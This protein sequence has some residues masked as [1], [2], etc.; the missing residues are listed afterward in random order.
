[1]IPGL[2]VEPRECIPERTVG[3]LAAVL[4]RVGMSRRMSSASQI[5]VLS[6]SCRELER[7]ASIQPS[8]SDPATFAKLYI[9]SQIIY[10]RIVR[11]HAWS[12]HS[13]QPGPALSD[14]IL[15]LERICQKLNFMFLNLNRENQIQIRV[16]KLKLLGIA[17][18]SVVSHSNK[19]ALGQTNDFI[20]E[21]NAVLMEL[22]DEEMNNQAFLSDFHALQLSEAKPGL[23][24]S[25]LKPLLLKHPPG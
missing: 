5:S 14:N 18:V 4:R 1:M 8:I 22:T 19:S 3:F 25:K 9:E 12:H 13:A 15:K 23:I 21:F 10:E 24:V 2:K 16:L 17:L 20:K 11:S 7:V 6:A